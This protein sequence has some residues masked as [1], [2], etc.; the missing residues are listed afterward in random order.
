MLRPRSAD[1]AGQSAY[2]PSL[3]ALWL[4]KRANSTEV[5][6]MA[7][8]TISEAAM[9]RLGRV[10][11]P[12]PASTGSLRI[13]VDHRCHC[14]GLKLG[15]EI[16]LAAE[17]DRLR[18]LSGLPVLVTPEVDEAPGTAAL[19]FLDSPFLSRFVLTNSEHHCE[20]QA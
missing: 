4:T 6:D 13:F 16:R 19:D 2:N 3:P 12:A 10:L 9:R 17:D 18:E 11:G 5:Y 7:T 14:G 8:I 1:A 20:Q 15:M